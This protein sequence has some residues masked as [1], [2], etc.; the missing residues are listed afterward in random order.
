MSPLV[1]PPPAPEDTVSEIFALP[2]S[3]N[4]PAPMAITAAPAS[5]LAAVA[6][7]SLATAVNAPLSVVTS[8]PASTMMLRPACKVMLPPSPTPFTDVIDSLIVI[9]LLA[10]RVTAAP[11][12]VIAVISSASKVTSPVATS[13]NWSLSATVTPPALSAMV[14]FF[15]SKRIDPAS[16]SFAPT[17]MEPR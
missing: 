14:I 4:E 7:T 2:V 9:S 12:F 6:P 17:S 15:G 1:W 10:W 16:P 5:L 11:E 13:P 3:I 8:T